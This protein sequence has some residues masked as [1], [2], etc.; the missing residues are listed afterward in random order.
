MTRSVLVTGANG[1][2][3]SHTLK[4]LAAMPGVTPIALLRDARRRPAGFDG[5]VRLGDIRDPAAV[6]RAL[7]GVDA[8]CACAAWTSAWGHA[9]A[10]R[11]CLLEPTLAFLD[12]AVARGIQRLV[13]PSSTTARVLRKLPPDSLRGAPDSVWPHMANVLRIEEHMR[14]LAERGPTMV[15]LRLG[16]FVGEHYGL[17]MLP[18]LLPRLRSH[19]VPW[20]ARGRTSLPLVAGEDIGRAMALAAIAPDL[21]GYVACDVV[22]GEIPTA[23][24]VLRFLHHA[25]GYPLP[26]FGVSFPLAYGFARLMEGLSHLTPW[27][28]FITRSVV[29]LL[30]ETAPDNTLAAQLF[31]Y[32]PRVHWKDAVRAQLAQMRRDRVRGLPMAPPLPAPLAPSHAGQHE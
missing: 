2:V 16:L 23:R 5:E 6:E 17:G 30:E 14:I 29:L 27:D 19:L 8:V 24:E 7:D 12:A 11:A 3:G 10:S 25:Y 21:K 13:F 32:A 18:I 9:E 1:F 26:H 20:V 31:G 4:A 28:P 22:G 15:A